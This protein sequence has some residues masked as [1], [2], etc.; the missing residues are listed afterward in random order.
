VCSGLNNTTESGKVAI[1]DSLFSAFKEKLERKE[2]I[3][4]NM[5]A[6]LKNGNW[7]FRAPMGYD[8][9]FCT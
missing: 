9:V 7:F 2:I 4:P 6:Y 5:A 8:H 1:W 3:I